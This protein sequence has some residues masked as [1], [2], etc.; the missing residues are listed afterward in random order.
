MHHKTVERIARENL[1]L[2]K[3]G[4]ADAISAKLSAENMDVLDIEDI[5]ERLQQGG[6][7]EP[8]TPAALPFTPPEATEAPAVPPPAQAPKAPVQAP[9]APASK[10]RKAVKQSATTGKSNVDHEEWAVRKL[11]GTDGTEDAHFKKVEYIKSVRIGAER[12]ARMNEQSK[13]T[14]KRY[15]A[16]A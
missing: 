8:E 2:F 6:L 5:I 15:Y 10:P 16:T 3:T 11:T 13:N 14:G 12:A 1:G 4:G 9:P 7:E